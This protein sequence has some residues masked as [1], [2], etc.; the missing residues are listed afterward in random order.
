MNFI[1]EIRSKCIQGGRGSKNPKMLWTSYL[2]APLDGRSS[3]VQDAESVV[4][5]QED[6]EVVP[7]ELED[8]ALPPEQEG[9]EAVEA[10]GGVLVH[11][12]VDARLQIL[13]LLPHFDLH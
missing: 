7:N 11:V 8:A 1:V 4:G 12:R 9:P 6:H 5:E 2:E 10:V 3:P 13:L